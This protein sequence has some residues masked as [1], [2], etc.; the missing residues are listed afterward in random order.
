MFL[1]IR[2]LELRKVRFDEDFP[3]GE[4]EFD[5]NIRQ[6]GPLN[7]AGFA[8]LL[9]N[10][11]GEI[12]IRGHVKAELEL[13]CDRCL[14]P[15]R[16]PIDQDFDLFYRPA[17]KAGNTPHEVAIDEGEAEIGF[18]EGL[19]LE[20]SEVVREHILLSLPMQQVCEE[21]CRGICPRCG[22]N[23]NNGDC[24]CTDQMVADRWAALRE[25][26]IGTKN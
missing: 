22:Q 10:T 14:E 24:S 26:K 19:G 6:L 8:E 16:Y 7:A 21:S 2:E 25:L 9:S 12:R 11:L 3:P 4:I 13:P 23:R 5:V 20:L 1:N 18:Y 17:P 15:V